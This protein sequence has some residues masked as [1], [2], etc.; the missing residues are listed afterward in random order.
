MLENGKYLLYL[1][2]G[3]RQRI[4]FGEEDKVFVG[5]VRL[6]AEWAIQKQEGSEESI[7]KSVSILMSFIYG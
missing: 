1:D 7:Y 5:D 6:I 2:Q 3:G 4:G